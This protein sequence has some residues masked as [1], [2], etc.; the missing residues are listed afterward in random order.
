MKNR[1]RR[2]RS[3]ALFSRVINSINNVPTTAQLCY[4]HAA[5]L[6]NIKVSLSPTA[7]R[8]THAVL[9]LHGIILINLHTRSSSTDTRVYTYTCIYIGCF[10]RGNGSSR[11]RSYVNAFVRN[12]IFPKRTTARNIVRANDGYFLRNVFIFLCLRRP[13]EALRS[14][15]TVFIGLGR[16]VTPRLSH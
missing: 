4:L 6:S 12:E 3:R 7:P 8:P 14:P 5:G 16:S 15:P 13:R 11:T 2:Q 9:V 10:E 1:F